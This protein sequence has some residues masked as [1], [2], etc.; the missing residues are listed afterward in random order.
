MP[1]SRL[2]IHQQTTLPRDVPQYDPN[3]PEGSLKRLIEYLRLLVPRADEAQRITAITSNTA[4]SDTAKL[5]AAAF[6]PEIAVRYGDFDVDK[7]TTA[8]VYLVDTSSGPITATLPRSAEWTNRLIVFTHVSA[9]SN[10]LTIRT[11]DGY[12]S[13]ALS[14]TFSTPYASRLIV[15]DGV[16]WWV[17]SGSFDT[18][19]SPE[20][21][22][23]E[24]GPQGP[25]GEPG[26]PG[27]TFTMASVV[28]DV[29]AR[30]RRGGR[31]IIEGDFPSEAVGGPVIVQQQGE[32]SLDT[33][34]WDH[35]MC[36]PQ[37][38][39]TRQL[40]VHWCSSSPVRGKRRFTYLFPGS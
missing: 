6:Q 1:N 22:V 34:E 31:F 17:I 2:A 27:T 25:Q 40:L 21:G 29:G 20:G 19:T 30:A 36:S 12:I 39:S 11:T 10:S 8:N 23:S 3:D 13:Q 15:C 33:G 32:E 4:A 14:I 38:V 5:S 9:D 28:V 16:N 18:F 26:T 37:L 35:V 7:D 24:A